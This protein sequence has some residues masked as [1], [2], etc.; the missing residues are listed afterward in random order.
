LVAADRF[1]GVDRL[2]D[3]KLRS[4]SAF[5][6][7]ENKRGCTDFHGSCPLTHVRVAEDD[8]KPAIAACVGMGLVARIDQRAAIHCVNAHQD[9]EKIRALRNLKNIRLARCAFRFDTHFSSAG[10]DLAGDE[11]WQN[12]GN[13]VVPCD[14]ATHQ[15][16]IVATVTVPDK[17]GIVLVKPNFI[18]GRQLLISPSRAFREDA[19]AGLILR[20]DLPK[21]GAFRGGIFRMRVIV[22]KTGAV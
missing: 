17:V 19:F 5:D 3:L 21:C 1:V 7:V 9:T 10:E 20:H 16:I 13:D 15:V 2:G 14:V 11:K 12:T 22:V 18:A 8:V 4:F 6:Q